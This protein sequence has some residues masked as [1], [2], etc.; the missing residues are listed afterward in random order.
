MSTKQKKQSVRSVRQGTEVASP[1]K[2]SVA[3]TKPS[4]PP[5]ICIPVVTNYS[6]M[7]QQIRNIVEDEQHHTKSLPDK[8]VI[9]NCHS[10]ES[11]RKLVKEKVIFHHAYQLKEER[12]H[13]EY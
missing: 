6:A 2:S 13:S 4:N 3:M 12:G 1:D 9:V 5:P 8:V 10:S 11:Y 7:V